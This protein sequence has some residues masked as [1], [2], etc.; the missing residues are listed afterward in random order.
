MLLAVDIGNTLIALG[1]IDH[2][3]VIVSEQ[4]ASKAFRTPLEYAID[5]KITLDIHGIKVSDLSGGIISSVFPAMT[6]VLRAAVEKLLPSPPLIVGPGI[7]TGLNIKIDNPSQ[8]GS[9]L[10]VGAVAAIAAYEPPM[11]LIEL[12]TATTFSVINRQSAYIGGVLCPGVQVALNSLS[13]AAAQLPGISF[14]APANAIGRNTID[15]MKSG[16]VYGNASM[17][18]GMIDR[19]EEELGESACIVAT[20]AYTNPII[21]ACRHKIIV[22]ETLTL[23]GLAIIHKK[24]TAAR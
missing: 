4:L 21:A 23:R 18:D 15:C 19:I 22:D 20:G 7:K 3:K 2:G 8:L 17:I 24:N 5:I 12:G 14:D 6:G 16:A 10:V 13:A 9:D 11:I 1:V